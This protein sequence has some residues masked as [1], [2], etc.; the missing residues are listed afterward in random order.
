MFL[1][2]HGLSLIFF[3]VLRCAYIVLELLI[4]MDCLRCA[5]IVIE[6]LTVSLI[7]IKDV[8]ICV[9]T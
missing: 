7:F 3:D 6:V 5:L 9:C 8:N 4:V 1:D 2:F